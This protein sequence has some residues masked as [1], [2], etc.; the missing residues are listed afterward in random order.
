MHRKRGISL[1]GNDSPKINKIL[2]QQQIKQKQILNI[3][4][5]LFTD[6]NSN[7]NGLQQE[8]IKINTQ[9]Q[10]FNAQQT[11]QSDNIQTLSN[12]SLKASVISNN[13]GNQ[14]DIQIIDKKQKNDEKLHP[15]QKNLDNIDINLQNFSTVKD[16]DSLNRTP[17]SNT[18]FNTENLNQSI[19]QFQNSPQELY[20]KNVQNGVN[21]HRSVQISPK[22]QNIT[23]KYVYI[24]NQNKINGQKLKISPKPQIQNLLK[25]QSVPVS[26]ERDQYLKKQINL[27]QKFNQTQNNKKEI[28][29]QIISD[30]QNIVQ[31]T[32]HQIQQKDHNLN[33][34]KNN[35]FKNK[36]NNLNQKFNIK[37]N[38]NQHESQNS[39]KNQINVQNLIQHNNQNQ[40]NGNKTHIQNYNNNKDMSDENQQNDIEQNNSEI[41][42][43]MYK[44]IVQK[45]N[46][47]K[48]A[49]QK[50][51]IGQFENQINN[52]SQK[53]N[54]ILERSKKL[55]EN[56]QQS[57]NSQDNV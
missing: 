5:A 29:F 25:Y 11:I 52:L 46:L 8:N 2:D 23:N 50:Q 7:T 26:P 35:N 17:D 47:N 38:I 56:L 49:K 51:E 53:V 16:K 19:Q 9:N 32:N 33:I 28:Q 18:K 13:L 45:N 37:S 42:T 20:N 44:N 30:Y 36:D 41:Y 39:F 3:T 31:G 57:Q 1:I 27:Q 14:D 55:T 24:L 54:L 40:D 21:Y 12:R 4:Q 22:N 43:Q 10:L 15:N 34:N 48:S 6:I